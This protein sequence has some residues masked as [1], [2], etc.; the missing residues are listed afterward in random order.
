M[1][2]Y[3]PL[4]VVQLLFGNAIGLERP[5]RSIQRLCASFLVDC[6]RM[7]QPNVS[8]SES[9][10][11]GLPR[12]TRSIM[13]AISYLVF[14]IFA[15][16]GIVFEDDSPW[17]SLVAIIGMFILTIISLRAAGTSDHARARQSNQTLDLASKTVTFMRQGLDMASAQAVCELLLPAA[18][19]DAVAL[20]NREIILGF[21]GVDKEDHPPNTPIQTLSTYMT[22]EDGITRVLETSTARDVSRSTHKL[23]AGIVVALVVDKHIVGA[24]KFY[25]RSSH[26]LGENQKAVA[27][28]FAQ[29]LSTQLSLSYLQ[30]QKELAA[31]ME[32]KALQAQINPHFLFNTINTI[33]SITRT[34]PDKAR[35]M[36]REFAVYYRR[37]LENADEFIPLSQE[38][39][40][41]ERYLLFQKARFGDDAINLTIDIEPG[42]EEMKTPSFMLQPLVENAVGHGRRDDG[43]PLSITISARRKGESVV[44]AVSDDG[45][46]IPPERLENLFDQKSETG[47]GI[48]LRNINARLKSFFGEISGI[49]IDSE[50]GKGT[51]VSLNLYDAHL[52]EDVEIVEKKVELSQEIP[53]I[54]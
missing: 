1:A 49:S 11:M 25:Y 21:A 15:I 19:A 45:V 16:I 14:S 37:M 27:E 34:D 40:Q 24:L 2:K 50:Y 53:K 32:L 20:T 13:L 7:M 29:L 3:R 18:T 5:F 51:T 46:G 8:R 35:V 36:L 38:V 10:V 41:T 43:T 31:K 47:M 28:G 42:L 30:Q 12:I 54:G 4:L 48:A 33:A 26:A 52:D 22:L 23:R 17:I 39:D 9:K 6:G 44:V